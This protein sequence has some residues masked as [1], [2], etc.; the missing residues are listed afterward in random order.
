MDLSYRWS[1]GR[2]ELAEG[3]LS[4]YRGWARLVSGC[5]YRDAAEE[6]GGRVKRVS[7]R[8]QFASESINEL[9]SRS[10]FGVEWNSVSSLERTS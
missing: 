3:N 1:L 8:V 7:N 10:L 9:M 4:H 2:E 6:V 5:G